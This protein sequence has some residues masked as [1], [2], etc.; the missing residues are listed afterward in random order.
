MRVLSVNVGESAPLSWNGQTVQSS[1]VKTPVAGPVRVAALGLDG[2]T[3]SNLKVHGGALKAV[4]AY[5]K[6]HYPFW[7]N[8]LDRTDL[9]DGM[10]GENLTIEEF[11]ESAIQVGDTF[12]IGSAVVMAVQPR[13]PC[14]KL[15]MRFQRSDMIERFLHSLRCGVYFSVIQE[16]TVTAGD[17]VQPLEKMSHGI[18]VADI[19]RMKLIEREDVGG[20]RSALTID[21]L[22]EKIKD[23]FKTRLEKL[24]A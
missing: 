7:E 23:L 18:S 9:P 3:Q 2:D 8:E 21:A 19:V 12:Q 6:N 1:I 17:T 16:G 15:A 4:Y 14:D 24:E 5:G 20:M 11:D 10:F 22:P 13:Q